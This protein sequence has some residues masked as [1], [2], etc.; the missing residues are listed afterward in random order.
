MFKVITFAWLTYIENAFDVVATGLDV[1][2]MAFFVNVTLM[3]VGVTYSDTDVTSPERIMSMLPVTASTAV[4]VKV[5]T[6]GATD[7]LVQVT[8]PPKVDVQE[9]GAMPISVMVKVA[10]GLQDA[11]T[12]IVA[13]LPTARLRVKGSDV[14]VHFGTMVNM[15][16]GLTVT[17]DTDVIVKATLVDTCP[18]I[19]WTVTSW[20]TEPELVY[21]TLPP[22][23]KANDRAAVAVGMSVTVPHSEHRIADS[24][25]FILYVVTPMM[26]TYL[27]IVHVTTL[28][29]SITSGTVTGVAYW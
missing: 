13:L 22:T 21:I 7:A 17:V 29:S 5:F 23:A 26:R 12:V 6:I 27:F 10:H 2:V 24:W 19:G 16:S 15:T 28:L 9:D 25:H 18:W 14:T 20:M 3:P 11:V 1:T 4:I 8:V